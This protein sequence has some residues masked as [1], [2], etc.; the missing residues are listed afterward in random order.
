MSSH[1]ATYPF[2]NV[3]KAQVKCCLCSWI[4]NNSLMIDLS[5]YKNIN[6]FSFSEKTAH[7]KI[8]TTISFDWIFRRHNKEILVRGEQVS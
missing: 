2:I 1:E 5:D 8:V 3:W 4:P 7:T 6:S